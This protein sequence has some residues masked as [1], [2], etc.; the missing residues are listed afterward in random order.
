MRPRT[1]SGFPS[2]VNVQMREAG[3]KTDRI[4]DPNWPKRVFHAINVM[5]SI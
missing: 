5:L 2:L 3:Q 1:L 4:I